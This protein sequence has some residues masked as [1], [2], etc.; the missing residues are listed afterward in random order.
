MQ[1][2]PL[3]LRIKGWFG[4][5]FSSLLCSII[6]YTWEGGWTQPVSF[7]RAEPMLVSKK[8][9]KEETSNGGGGGR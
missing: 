5:C 4:L 9:T 2:V 6:V 1:R 8:E 7:E 3:A